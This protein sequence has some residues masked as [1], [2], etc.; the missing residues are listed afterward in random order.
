MINFI[1]QKQPTYSNK[2]NYI[3]LLLKKTLAQSSRSAPL[4]NSVGLPALHHRNIFR[5]KK[6]VPDLRQELESGQ[7]NHIM[8]LYFSTYDITP[9]TAFR[10]SFAPLLPPSGAFWAGP[11]STP[12]HKR[13]VKATSPK[14]HSRLAYE[15]RCRTFQRASLLLVS[16]AW[17][18]RAYR[19]ANR[20]FKIESEG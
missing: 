2:H 10:K 13:C 15:V 9:C 18:F 16:S 3:S 8:K 17:G 4:R 19:R 6:D 5:T 20:L 11:R 14:A 7:W 12:I 1:F